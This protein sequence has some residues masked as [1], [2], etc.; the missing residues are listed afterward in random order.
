MRTFSQAIQKLTKDKL[1][2]IVK[3]GQI[4]KIN[5]EDYVKNDYYEKFLQDNMTNEDVET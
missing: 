5:V 1:E 3:S 4:D 2:N